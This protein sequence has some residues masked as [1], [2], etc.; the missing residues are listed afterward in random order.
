MATIPNTINAILNYATDHIATWNTVVTAGGPGGANG[1]TP[2]DITALQ[3]A[4]TAADTSHG[5]AQTARSNSKS[6]TAL[7][8][9]DLAS[10]RDL[11]SQSINKIK[12]YAAGSADPVTVYTEMDVPEPDTTPTKHYPVTPTM[13][14]AQPSADGTIKLTW[15]ASTNFYGT[16]YLVEGSADGTTWSTVSTTTAQKITLTGYTPGAA[17]WFRVSARHNGQTSVPTASVPVWGTGGT[18]SL[19][20]AA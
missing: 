19:T 2:A 14:V 10:L 13:L 1:L 16:T 3:A 12:N 9:S 15:D 4:L 17:Y 11:L 6:A 8:N 20:I 18:S 5:A 7:Q